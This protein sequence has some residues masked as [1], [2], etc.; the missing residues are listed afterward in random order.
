MPSPVLTTKLRSGFE[1]EYF[2]WMHHNH[3]HKFFCSQRS[4]L[5]PDYSRSPHHCDNW[6]VKLSKCLLIFYRTERVIT[7]WFRAPDTWGSK[8]GLWR[9]GSACR[10]SLSKKK[11]VE[12][13]WRWGWF[14][15]DLLHVLKKML[16][17]EWKQSW[18]SRSVCSLHFLHRN[19]CD[20][21]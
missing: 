18:K 7:S 11:E 19:M 20:R 15:N 9:K 5:W 10:A 16:W 2:T 4:W 14:R 17:E 1:D 13:Q 21:L 6:W 12:S 3:T 8:T